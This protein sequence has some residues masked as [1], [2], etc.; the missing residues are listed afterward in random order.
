MQPWVGPHWRSDSLIHQ[1]EWIGDLLARKN[2]AVWV[3]T[4]WTKIWYIVL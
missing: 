3:M 1:R 2:I 4:S